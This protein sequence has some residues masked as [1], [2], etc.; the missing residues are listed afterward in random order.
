[1]VL[2]TT[3]QPFSRGLRYPNESD[4]PCE[5]L[6]VWIASRNW[7]N[8]ELVRQML[9][10]CDP[11]GVKS[12]KD[13]IFHTPPHVEAEKLQSCYQLCITDACVEGNG[14]LLQMWLDQ[15]QNPEL[16][17]QDVRIP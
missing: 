1:M 14:T 3:L 5:R 7:R 9:H 13:L 17:L 6:P 15:S 12:E 16:Y 4:L 2:L 8:A 11:S 10:H